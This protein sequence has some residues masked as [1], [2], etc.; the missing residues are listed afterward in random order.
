MRS[1]AV[2]RHGLDQA[3]QKAGIFTSCRIAGKAF[4]CRQWQLQRGAELCEQGIIADGA[5]K[6]TVVGLKGFKQGDLRMS[7]A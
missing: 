7:C 5:D 1:R 3:F 6:Q 2:N 4:V